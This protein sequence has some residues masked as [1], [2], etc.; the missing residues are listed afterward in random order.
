MIKIPTIEQMNKNIEYYCSLKTDEL[1]TFGKSYVE[2][3]PNTFALGC[4]VAPSNSPSAEIILM[5][6]LLLHSLE[7]ANGPLRE[8]DMDVMSEYLLFGHLNLEMDDEQKETLYPLLNYIIR[9]GI[10]LKVKP[11][12][13][14]MISFLSAI[15][16]S[17]AHAHNYVPELLINLHEENT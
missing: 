8:S 3:Y 7:S 5:G 4:L 16:T 2:R 13:E 11:T 9:V 15:L 14:D 1:V 12:D 6:A 10:N 17:I